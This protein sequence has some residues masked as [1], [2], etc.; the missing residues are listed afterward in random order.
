MSQ[1]FRLYLED[2]IRECN[3]PLHL[4]T[5]RKQAIVLLVRSITD[6]KNSWW[7][8]LIFC[9]VSF[10][11]GFNHIFICTPWLLWLPWPY[12]LYSLYL[13][14]KSFTIPL[15]RYEREK[16]CH[17]AVTPGL[18]LQSCCSFL[19]FPAVKCNNSFWEGIDYFTQSA[20]L[21]FHTWFQETFSSAAHKC[22]PKLDLLLL[23]LEGSLKET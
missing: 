23:M 10:I 21:I 19:F 6:K 11:L 22:Y 2:G 4:K 20:V 16:S 13:P 15:C 5:S 18:F 1:V 3:A 17:C 8:S 7:V 14:A 12:F 9:R